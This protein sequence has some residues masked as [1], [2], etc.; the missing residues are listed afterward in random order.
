M[1]KLK[2]G[3]LFSGYGGLDLAVMKVLD[4]EVVWHCEWDDAPSKILE[5]HF[6]NVP[7][8]RDV[9]K[10]DFSQ[11]EPV[12]VLTGGFPCQDL[13]LAGKRAGL[14]EGTRSGL[15]SEFARAIET[16]KPKLVVIE[17]VRG[18]L[19]AK[20][21]NGME[22][23]QED[24]D[25]FGGGNLFAPWELFSA[26][27]PISGM[28]RNGQACELQMQVR[29]ITDSESSLLPIPE[30]SILRTPSVTDSTGGAISET[31]ARDRG[32]MVKVA[33]QVAELAFEN[34]LKVTPAIAA[35]L[36]PT[37]RAQEPGS[38][39][40]GYGDSLNDFANRVVNGFAPKDLL[41]TPA[42]GHIRN[43]DEPIQNYLERRQD[44]VDGKTKGM[45]GASLG[46][47]VRMEMLPT[48][49]TQDG[50]NNAGKS[51]FDRN[52]LPLNAEVTLLPINW[53]KFEPAIRR[54][55]ELTR[56]APAPTKP[57][58]KDGAH[59]L[60]AEFTEWMMG[61]PAGWITSPDL[62][63]TRN[64]QLK[65]CGNGVVPQQA[66]LALRMLLDQDLLDQL[67]E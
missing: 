60:S 67:T 33:D 3:S 34:N 31:Q 28:M 7:N 54:W 56:P 24:L 4:A 1:S 41:P 45:L 26:T 46:V 61:L 13:S 27:W 22:Y 10:V 66:E 65:A 36:L 40:A 11:V 39:S 14:E 2:I 12:D 23:T 59:R 38:T 55:E 43:H 19:S 48:P 21:N 6:P 58:G 29:H 20:A 42:V 32:R 52:T 47:A 5:N 63:L 50:K 64:E 15:W 44:F 51:Q 25:I 35:S 53:G 18:L 17:N 9:T 8:Y 62:G 37:P 57:D 16:I 49:T 30:E